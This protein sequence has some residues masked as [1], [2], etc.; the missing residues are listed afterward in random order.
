MYP[1]R[2]LRVRLR[3]FSAMEYFTSATKAFRVA[4]EAAHTHASPGVNYIGFAI[5]PV[6]DDNPS[7]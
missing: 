3:G 4:F 2:L 5:L 6:R 7:A 1:H